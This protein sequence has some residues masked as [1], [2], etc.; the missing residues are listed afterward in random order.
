ME[1]LNAEQYQQIPLIAIYKELGFSAVAV[2]NHF[3]Y[4]GDGI[5]KKEYID[6][7]L[8]DF[9]EAEEF[10]KQEGIKVYLGAE[11]KF[12]ENRNEYILSIFKRF[13]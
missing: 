13:T 2:T 12:T 11:I 1:T 10:G 6:C 5:S 7:Y 3:L 4:R 8:K 9:D